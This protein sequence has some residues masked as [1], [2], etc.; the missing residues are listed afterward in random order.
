MISAALY[1][2]VEAVQALV[3]AGGDVNA[4]N[5]DGQT[6]LMEASRWGHVSVVRYLL[7]LPQTDLLVSDRRGQTA[8]Q[9]ADARGHVDVRDGIRREVGGCAPRP[10]YCVTAVTVWCGPGL[11]PP[12][13]VHARRLVV[14]IGVVIPCRLAIGRRGGAR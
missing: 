9:Y 10:S 13:G 12:S 7:T 2:Q 3:G 1:G 6:P 4:A 14:H 8:D 11:P 5:Y